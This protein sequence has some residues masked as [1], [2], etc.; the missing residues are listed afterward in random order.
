MVLKLRAVQDV[1]ENEST[2]FHPR[3]LRVVLSRRRLVISTEK[4]TQLPE[5][6]TKKLKTVPFQNDVTLTA[7]SS[8]S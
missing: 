4:L 3:K 7:C 8:T 2:H 1:R 5:V 6:R